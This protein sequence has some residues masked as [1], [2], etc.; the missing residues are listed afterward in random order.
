[1]PLAKAVYNL[2]PLPN[3]PCHL[4]IHQWRDARCQEPNVSPRFVPLE[5]GLGVV[6]LLL[7]VAW[8]G[9]RL[10]VWVNT[11]DNRYLLLHF[12]SPAVAVVR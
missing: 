1:M 8:H 12:S 2:V 4:L 6:S 11:I 5:Q 7:A 10:D 3:G 9:E